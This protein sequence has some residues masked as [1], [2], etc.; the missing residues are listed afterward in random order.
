[1]NVLAKIPTYETA[2]PAPVREVLRGIGQVFFQGSAISGALML[3]GIL[4]SSPLMA[5]GGAVGAIIGTWT[6]RLLKFSEAEIGDGIYGFNAALVGIATFFFFQAGVASVALML[7]GCVIATLVTYAA[8]RFVPFPTYTA[9]FVLVTWVLFLIGPSLGAARVEAGAAPAPSNL[10]AVEAVAHGI[11]QV[12]FQGNILTGLLFLAGIAVS[13]WRHAAWVLAGA[14]I[15]LLVGSYHLTAAARA[16]DPER[17]VER[18]LSENIA[19]GLYGYNATLAAVALYLWRR[20]LIPALL[21]AV[22]AVLLTELVPKF[23]IPALTAPFVLATW[24]VLAAGWADH[25]LFGNDHATVG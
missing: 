16:I 11:G 1:M 12:M 6:A 23:G 9:P 15:G 17:L 24:L 13:D 10:F 22:L 20:S 7:V 21:G 5:L 8:R 2:I 19:L 3:L 18:A 25:Q 14:I 4:V